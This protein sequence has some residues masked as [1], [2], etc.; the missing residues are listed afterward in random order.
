MKEIILAPMKLNLFLLTWTEEIHTSIRQNCIN[1]FISFGTNYL[2]QVFRI[3]P[4]LL[5]E[6]R[7]NSGETLLLILT[8][9]FCVVESNVFFI[10]YNSCFQT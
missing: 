8:K 7:K 5:E 4:F 6:I 10:F 1:V 2:F 9:D 3:R